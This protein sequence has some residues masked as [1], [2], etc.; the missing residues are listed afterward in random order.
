VVETWVSS[1]RCS[2][3]AGAG[4]VVVI[5]TGENASIALGTLSGGTDVIAVAGVGVAS[6]SSG[7]FGAG[8]G[9]VAAVDDECVSPER[10]LG[11]GIGVT[12]ATGADGVSTGRGALGG[13]TGVAAMFGC[14]VSTALG[15]IGA[16]T[17]VAAGGER[18]VSNGACCFC[19]TAKSWFLASGRVVCEGV[20]KL[21]ADWLALSLIV[22]KLGIRC[23]A[24]LCSTVD[25]STSTRRGMW[26]AFA[27]E[28]ARCSILIAAMLLALLVCGSVVE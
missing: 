13:G 4:V 3:G 17:N 28:G 15:V 7:A 22:L 12:A 9:F 1:T 20:S 6:T 14:V 23:D 16:G 10:W 8:N 18:D 26:G 19:L 27:G 5:A 21:P 2:L 11:A 25:S 24:T